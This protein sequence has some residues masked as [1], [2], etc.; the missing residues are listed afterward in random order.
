MTQRNKPVKDGEVLEDGQL[1]VVD[2]GVLFL[3]CCDCNLTHA[4]TFYDVVKRGK[5]YCLAVPTKPIALRLFRDKDATSW[6][7]KKK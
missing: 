7:K 1:V 6:N 3:T 2:D 5:E 4:I